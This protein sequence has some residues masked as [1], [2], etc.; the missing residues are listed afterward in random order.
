MIKIVRNAELFMLGLYACDSQCKVKY[1]TSV[2]C[3]TFYRTVAN[4]SSPGRP[5]VLFLSKNKKK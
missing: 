3:F 2:S 1:L 5:V 4:Q